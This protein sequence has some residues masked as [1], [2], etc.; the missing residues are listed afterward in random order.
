MSG[1]GEV[2]RSAESAFDLRA[3]IP[4]DLNI[5]VK[6]HPT[7]LRWFMNGYRGRSVEHYRAIESIGNTILVSADLDSNMLIENSVFVASIAGTASLQC[8]LRGKPAIIFGD[9]WFKGAPNVFDFSEISNHSQLST[10]SSEE[11]QRSL[12][13]FIELKTICGLHN[14]SG[15]NGWESIVNDTEFISIEW[16]SMCLCV[17]AFIGQECR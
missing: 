4:N 15:E 6:E 9:A 11:V 14:P 8:A 17:E 7:Q 2:S 13:N 16:Q 5:V 3:S 10:H 12:E 1:W